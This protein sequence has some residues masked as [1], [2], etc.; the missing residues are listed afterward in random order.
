MN[1]RIAATALYYLSSDNI[2][3]THLDFRALT[4]H[5]PAYGRQVGQN[6][7]SWLESVLGTGLSAGA[8][9]LQRYGSVLTRAGRMLA[10]PNVFQ[11]RVGGFRLV[12][13]TRPGHRRFVALWLVDPLTR[14]ISAGNVPPQ[15]AGWWAERAFGGIGKDGEGDEGDAGEGRKEGLSEP[16]RKVTPEIAQL[17]A[18]RGIAREQL[19]EVLTEGGKNAKLPPEVMNMVRKELDDTALP[20]TREEAEAHRLKLMQARTAF[21]QEARNDWDAVEYSF[22]EH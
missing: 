22:C 14:V 16:G 12:D 2:T 8:S 13:P 1:E 9:C 18:E 7:Y 6:A 11:H 20:M 4:S 21:Q 3:D 19:A 5:D 17:L 10:F 15:Q